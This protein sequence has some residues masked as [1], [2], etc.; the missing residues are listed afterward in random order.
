M[1]KK[2][3]FCM[4]LVLSSGSVYSSYSADF[5]LVNKSERKLFLLKNGSIFKEYNVSLGGNPKGHKQFQGD[6]RTPEGLYTITYRN[7]QSRFHHSLYINYPNST[8]KQ[9][10]RRKG[11]SPG[12]D[13]FIHGMP[14]NHRDPQALVNKDWTDGCVALTDPEIMEIS[15]YVKDGTPIEILP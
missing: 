12:G 4:P 2:L 13:I 14:N 15:R 5:V 8:D 6:K 10:A 1:L 11:R 7:N 3:L 9:Q